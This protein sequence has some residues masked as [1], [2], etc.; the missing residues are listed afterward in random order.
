[1]TMDVQDPHRRR[2]ALPRSRERQRA[3]LAGVGGVG[4]LVGRGGRWGQGLPGGGEGGGQGEW[5]VLMFA[6]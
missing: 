5:G 1:M 2:R 3:R 6:V 4:R